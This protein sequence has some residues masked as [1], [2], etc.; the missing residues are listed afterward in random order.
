M[1]IIDTALVSNGNL[2]IQLDDGTV[3]NA[4]RVAGP[5]GPAGRDGQDGSPGIPGAKGDAGENGAKWH[6]G[7]GAPE[8]SLGDAGDLYMDVANALLPIYQKVGRDWIFLANLKPTPQF[9]GGGEGAAGG[10]GSVIIKPGPEA[11]IVDNDNRPIQEGDLWVDI[12]GNHLYVYYNGVWSE[13]TT[14]SVGGGGGGADQMVFIGEKP[15]SKAPT[16]S[17][18]TDEETLKQFVKQEN[19]T[20]VEI[21][22]CGGGGDTD[23][24]AILKTINPFVEYAPSSETDEDIR[25]YYVSGSQYNI[26]VSASYNVIGTY[27]QRVEVDPQGNGNW[28]D[29]FN[30]FTSGEIDAM[31]LSKGSSGSTTYLFGKPSVHGGNVSDPSTWASPT[32]PNLKVR[33]WAT[34]TVNDRTVTVYTDEISPWVPN[35]IQ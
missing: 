19:G 2:L 9:A 23:L 29:V 3:V 13:V 16:G 22:G 20:W 7:V 25:V 6:T 11:P 21:T 26:R 27:Q 35:H 15:P 32:Y 8:V 10:G 31:S 12:N 33:Y 34:N 14:C 24:T 4:G 5:Q 28:G 17:I 30:D 1:A 18:F